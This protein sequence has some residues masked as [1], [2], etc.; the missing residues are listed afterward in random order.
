MVSNMVFEVGVEAT[1]KR[2]IALR[3][4]KIESLFPVSSDI[5][6][7]LFDVVNYMCKKSRKRGLVRLQKHEEFWIIGWTLSNDR[8]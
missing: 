3:D 5:F 8:Y 6:P 2:I 1:R 7:M 4:I